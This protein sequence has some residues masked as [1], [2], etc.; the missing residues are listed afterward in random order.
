MESLANPLAP[1][2]VAAS[3]A[4]VL[5]QCIAEEGVPAAE[6]LQAAGLAQ[7]PA[8]DWALD[9]FLNLLQ[10]AT[11]AE[12][13]ADLAPALGLRL[14]Q[15]QRVHSFG[16]LGLLLLSCSTLGEALQQVLRFEALVH[17]LGRS[18]FEARGDEGRL[19]WTPAR[20]LDAARH[21]LLIDWIFA[22]LQQVCDWLSGRRMPLRALQLRHLPAHPAAHQ[23]F[24]RAPLQAAQ[25]DAL[26]FD[27]GLLDWRL[28]QAD[29]TLQPALLQWAEKALA[30]R[31]RLPAWTPRVR[32]LLQ[33]DLAQG[34]SLVS[35]AAQ[36]DLS[37]RSLQRALQ[38]EGQGFQAL[39][40]GVRHQQ[41]CD[42]LRHGR[43]PLA[44]VASLLG[45]RHASA[46][47]QAFSQWQGCSPR[48]Y[49]QGGGR[50]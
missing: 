16:L 13:S 35:V 46:F 43:L 50:S 48:V 31:L 22:G 19:I 34:P 45:F 39:L 38:A 47:S 2:R 15:R 44:E 11:R 40:D 8:E 7:Q 18:R 21:A 42:Y 1:A 14:G 29:P 3:Y 33:R 20:E 25:Q 24:F 28:P 41:A 6:L 32:A 23:A 49:R 30:Q 10:A 9:D 5:L 37:S 12:V 4:Q 36:L 27:V 17:D 26:V